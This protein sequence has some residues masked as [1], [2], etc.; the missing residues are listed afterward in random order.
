M[1][2]NMFFEMKDE[3]KNHFQPLK[4]AGEIHGR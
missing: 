2:V 3:P 4:L 1:V